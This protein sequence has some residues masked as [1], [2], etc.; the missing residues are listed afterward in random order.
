MSSHHLI[1]ITKVCSA[2]KILTL[3]ITS[4]LLSMR[5]KA[6]L[7]SRGPEALGCVLLPSE[8]SR[9]LLLSDE[10]YRSGCMLSVQIFKE[11]IFHPSLSEL[12]FIGLTLSHVLQVREAEG[13]LL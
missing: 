12:H 11:L 13:R 1:S 8:C 2:K 6:E 5:G 7:K 3:K 4:G 10:C 9:G